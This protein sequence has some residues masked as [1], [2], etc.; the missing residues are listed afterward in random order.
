MSDTSAIP[1]QPSN[2]RKAPRVRRK[3]ARPGELLAAALELFVEKG[4][5]ATRVEEVASRA[6]VSKGTLFVYF[7]NKKELLKA[8]VRA[9]ISVH[10]NQ[11]QALLEHER[12]S[13]IDLL[14]QGL[15]QWWNNIGSTSA[16]G[17]TKLMLTEANNFPDVADFYQEEVIRPGLDIVEQLLRRG[18]QRGELRP[19]D[20]Q[21]N[22][23]LMMGTLVF[24]S[25]N[26]QSPALFPQGP[27]ALLAADYLDAYLDQLIQGITAPTGSHQLEHTPP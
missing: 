10:L 19:M 14:R 20:T 12:S 27:R 8:V 23:Y 26:R 13:T 16:G 21:H 18:V 4:F 2:C 3:E 15:R 17:I 11:W 25:L 5:K 1:S 9:N 6:G 7:A 24:L 22:A